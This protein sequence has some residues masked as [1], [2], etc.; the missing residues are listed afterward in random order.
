MNLKTLAIAALAAALAGGCVN[1]GAQVQA[2]KTQEIVTSPK[3]SVTVADVTTRDISETLEITGELTTSQDGQIGAKVGGRIVSVYVRD[4]DRVSAGQLIAEIDGANQRIQVQQAQAQVAAANSALS[5]A[6]ANATVGPTRSSAAVAQAQAQLRSARAQL[7][8]A[9][10]GAR[11][12]EKA[13]AEAAVAGAKSNLDTAKK[14]LERVRS[15]FN[16]QV[17]SQ[18][19]LDQAENAYNGAE[20]QYRQAQEQLRMVQSAVRA[21]DITSARETVRQ[22]EEAVRTAEATKRLDILLSQQV[23]SAQANLASARAQ[24]ALAQ[25]SLSDLQVR[26]PYPGQISGRPLQIGTVVAPGSPIARIVGGDGTYLEGD[27][28]AAMMT[29]IRVGSTVQVT[30][31]GLTGRRFTG[32][33]TSISP[34]ASSIGRIFKARVALISASPDIKPGMFARGSITLRNIP[35][36]VV[37]PTESLINRGDRTLV[38]I[39]DGTKAKEVTVVPGLKSD[40]YTQVNGVQ[41]GQKVIT[42]GQNDLEEGAELDIQTKKAEGGQA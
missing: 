42:S 29:Q 3:K 41:A 25:Q 26:A 6:R 23:Q 11:P 24:L 27:L 32:T 4:G 10:N 38:F 18:Q 17:V 8:K 12:E 2:K 35:G 33:I 28:P 36:A 16:E 7:Q 19:R 30:V 5:Q 37:V 1:R 34:S 15:L 39:A 22:A 40:G 20:A 14:E 21:E 9:L 31:D 13:Q